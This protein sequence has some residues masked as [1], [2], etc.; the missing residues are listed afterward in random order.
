MTCKPEA[1]GGRGNEVSCRSKR[2]RTLDCA[3]RAA[4]ERIVHAG[5][6]CR[7][8]A[9]VV[10]AQATVAGDK[11]LRTIPVVGD[12]DGVGGLLNDGI[13]TH[14]GESGIRFGSPTEYLE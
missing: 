2:S 4:P 5:R 6:I 10:A 14:S 3:C 11:I 9:D 8:T 1:Y 13:T 12:N 7:A